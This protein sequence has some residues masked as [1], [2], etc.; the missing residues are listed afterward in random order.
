VKKT[1]LDNCRFVHGTFDFGELPEV[2]GDESV[3]I[4][5]DIGIKSE[6]SLFSEA[7]IWIR[8][9]WNYLALAETVF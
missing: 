1:R 4:M 2:A 7:Q 9:R 8:R 6:F 3:E 5:N